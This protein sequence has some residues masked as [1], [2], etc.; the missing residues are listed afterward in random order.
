[1]IGRGTHIP[2]LPLSNFDGST[3]NGVWQLIVEDGFR[4]DGGS[5]NSWGLEICFE[6]DCNLTVTNVNNSGSGSLVEAINC[7][8]PGETIALSSVLA[9]STINLGSNQMVIDKNLTITAIKSDNIIV[10]YSG[11]GSA[12]VLNSGIDLNLIGFSLTS[13]SGNGETLQNN[14]NLTITDL[15]IENTNGNSPIINVDGSTLEV[16]GDCVIIDN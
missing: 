15:S 13:S 8:Q 1:M 10:N 2:E 5:L 6:P 3:I 14:G 16:L 4:R 7:A 9:N 12:L 11:D